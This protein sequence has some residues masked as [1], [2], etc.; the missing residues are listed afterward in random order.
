MIRD[1]VN[2]ISIDTN[3]EVRSSFYVEINFAI[4]LAK[5]TFQLAINIIINKATWMIRRKYYDTENSMICDRLH[6]KP[7]R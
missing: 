2:T 5:Q 4:T 7:C 3:K 6:S 1:Y